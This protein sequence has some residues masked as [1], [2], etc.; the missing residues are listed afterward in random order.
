MRLPASKIVRSTCTVIEFLPWISNNVEA[1]K[2]VRMDK[3]TI[4]E[5]DG[6]TDRQCSW[7]DKM[8]RPMVAIR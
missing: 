7:G 6:L 5:F 8:V 1:F 2:K 4:S 3:Q